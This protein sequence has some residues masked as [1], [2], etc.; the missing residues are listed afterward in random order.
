MILEI[1]QGKEK[2][3]GKEKGGYEEKDV[4]LSHMNFHRYHVVGEKL[5]LNLKGERPTYP[6]YLLIIHNIPMH[7]FFNELDK[8]GGATGNITQSDTP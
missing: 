3:Q 4:P 7:R 5:V 6:P 1:K 2:E 8:I